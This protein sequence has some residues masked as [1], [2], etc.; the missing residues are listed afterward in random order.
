MAEL[1]ETFTYSMI[2]QWLTAYNVWIKSEQV[3]EITELIWNS[4]IRIYWIWHWHC[5]Q[6]FIQARTTRQRRIILKRN[7]SRR[8]KICRCSHRRNT[9]LV[10]YPRFE[11]LKLSLG[12]REFLAGWK[13]DCNIF[14]VYKT[15]INDV[16]YY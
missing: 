6:G 15:Y 11:E 14:Q 12:A 3:G 2:C 13:P 4:P 16:I 5:N 8:A 9:K 10:I 1:F 7:T